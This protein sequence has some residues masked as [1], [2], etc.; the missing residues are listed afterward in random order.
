MPFRG[1]VVFLGFLAMGCGFEFNK[2]FEQDTGTGP[3]GTGVGSD[4]R[5]APGTDTGT[6]SQTAASTDTGFQT[7]ETETQTETATGT[8]AITS[9]TLVHRWRFNGD[10]TDEV[11][12]STAEIVTPEEAS[13]VN[14][15]L[16]E[17]AITLAGG[18]YNEASYVSLGTHLLSSVQ[19]AVSIEIFATLWGVSYFPRI[20]EFGSGLYNYLNMTWTRETDQSSDGVIWWG[21]EDMNP[22]WGTNAPYTIGQEYHIL[23]TVDPE[24]G[25]NGELRIAWYTAPAES[26]GIGEERGSIETDDPLDSLND[27][28]CWLGK[29]HSDADAVAHARYNDVRIWKGVISPEDAQLLHQ[30]GPDM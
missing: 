26:A 16:S 5:V 11:G 6:A 22:V 10:L 13:G 12:G 18:A 27:V 24:G 3:G 21:G 14:V 23:L 7:T 9:G 19:G 17:R 30:L 1:P 15:A 4:T 8:G 2:T 28:H 29:S 20:F 25:E